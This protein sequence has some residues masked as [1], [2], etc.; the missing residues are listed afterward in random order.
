MFLTKNTLTEESVSRKK[1]EKEKETTEFG[2][3]KSVVNTHLTS[4]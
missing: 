3:T 1:K 4:S 2:Q